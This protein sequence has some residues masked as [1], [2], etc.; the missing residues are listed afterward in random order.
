M[1]ALLTGLALATASV[2]GFAPDADASPG[3]HHH[4]RHR[5]R[6]G[7]HIGLGGVGHS[8][9]GYYRTEWQWVQQTTVVGYDRFG[10][11][12]YGSTWVQQPIQVWVPHQVYVRP[13]V[14][15]GFG[16]RW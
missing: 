3:H 9:G 15:V 13:A 14:S 7:I 8:Q 5:S 10:H 6:G 1:K 2:V 4:H 12:V 16:F 11:P